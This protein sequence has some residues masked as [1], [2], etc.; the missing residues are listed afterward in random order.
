MDRERATVLVSGVNQENTMPGQQQYA[1]EDLNDRVVVDRDGA[2]IGKVEDVFYDNDTGAPE[3]LLVHTGL[4]GMR[5]TFVPLA[6]TRPQG[7]DIVVS[8]DKD[9]V[10]DA[11][12]V[13]NEDELSEA[14]EQ[15]LAAYYSLEYT[16][17]PQSNSERGRSGDNAMTRSEEELQVGTTRRPSELV[18]LKKHVVTEHQQVTVPVQHEEVR[19]EREPITDANRDQALSG[20][21]ITES[22]HAVT[23]NEEQ[24]EVSKRV[25][26][27]ERVRLDKDTVTE[28]ETVDEEV[29]KERIDVEHDAGS[30]H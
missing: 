26:P 28:Q 6:A 10:K 13:G 30:R 25:V 19:I 27:K 22:E 14:D 15:T 18:R 4:F 9:F 20:D 21:D 24:V 1:G 23:L 2:K 7:D 3:W 29:R 11:P 17:Q 12:N 8:Y 5:A 16:Q